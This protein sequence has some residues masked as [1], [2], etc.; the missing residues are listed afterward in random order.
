MS[1]SSYFMQEN[2]ADVEREQR[3]REGRDAHLTSTQQCKRSK[4]NKISYAC[5]ASWA[6]PKFF[7]SLII[8]TPPL[9]PH[10]VHL[11]IEQIEKNEKNKIKTKDVSWRG[12]TE[13]FQGTQALCHAMLTTVAWH[14]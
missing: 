12:G 2:A 4:K 8:L 5:W 9:L 11:H 13:S 3:G 14:S 1:L 6:P 10:S 7:Q